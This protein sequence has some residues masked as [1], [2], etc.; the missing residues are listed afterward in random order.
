MQGRPWYKTDYD[1]VHMVSYCYTCTIDDELLTPELESHEIANGM[2]P[3]WI[4]I[5]DAI[6]HNEHTIAHSEK[7]GMSI[8]RETFL[9]KLIVEELIKKQG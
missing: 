7:K 9:L 5:H 1:I 2:H 3:T 4:N 6:A 8:E